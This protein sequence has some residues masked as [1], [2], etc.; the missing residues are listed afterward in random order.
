M[1]FHHVGQGCL[2]YLFI[3]EA[4]AFSVAQARVL[5]CCQADIELL[6][7]SDPPT[8]AS[9]N[10]RIRGATFKSNKLHAIIPGIRGLALSSRVECSG[11]NTA[12]CRLYLLGSSSPPASASRVAGTTGVHHHTQLITKM[13]GGRGGRVAGL[14]FLALS[15]SPTSAS[16]DAG[17]T[18]GVSLCHPGWSAVARSRF[19]EASVSWVQ[20]ILLPQPPGQLGLSLGSRSLES[21]L[22]D[23]PILLAFVTEDMCPNSSCA[24]PT[25]SLLERR[26]SPEAGKMLP[27][28]MGHRKLHTR[29]WPC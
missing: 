2:V 13:L 24:F 27:E 9:Q 6:A 21:T 23:I 19:T 18:D 12:H 10:A 16:P 29:R 15:H 22:L 4:G 28:E 7:S 5:L 17:I 14:R 25:Q 1:G 8:S 20:E 26:C 11:D 3:F